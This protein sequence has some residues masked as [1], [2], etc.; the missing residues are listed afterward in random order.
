VLREDKKEIARITIRCI[1]AFAYIC[2]GFHY[3]FEVLFPKE[4]EIEEEHEHV[5]LRLHP[6]DNIVQFRKHEPIMQ[7]D[8]KHDA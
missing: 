4:E 7:E 6:I 5:V 1:L 8:N 3:I 2:L